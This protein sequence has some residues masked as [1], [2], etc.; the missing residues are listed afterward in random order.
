MKIFSTI[1][2]WKFEAVHWLRSLTTTGLTIDAKIASILFAPKR[3]DYY[4][5]LADTIQGTRGR[6]SLI[7]I[8]ASDVER[9]GTSARG[10][11]SRHWI[12][13][14]KSGGGSLQKT[15]AGTLP[16]A[17]V[18]VLDTLL[19]S[20]GEKALENALRDLSAN[21]EL[22]SKARFVVF[23]STIAGFISLAMTLVMFIGMP[24]YTVPKMVDAFSM[25]PLSDYPESARSLVELADFVKESSITIVMFTAAIIGLII[26]SLSN[27]TG[28]TRHYLD[29]YGLFWALHRDF[30]SIRFLSTL[31]A[32]VR[33]SD[34]TAVN[35]KD[36]LEMQLNGA[37]RWKK[38][39]LNS[40]LSYV[41]RGKVGPEIFTTGIMDK[42]MQ[43][44][45]SDL[46]ESRGF[47]DALQFVKERLKERVIKRITVQSVTV[48]WLL[49]FAS[50]A[51]S[52][53]LLKWHMDALDD[54]K[55]ALQLYMG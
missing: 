44:Y 8:F 2:K 21:S 46:I 9:Y 33:Q 11:L 28:R 14:F 45:I 40:I 17:D 32:L 25:L 52:A 16:A 55:S 47:S 50:L 20:G 48:A 38:Y 1:E 49:M 5:F 31:A 3:A 34:N 18:V 35:L 54:M 12:K 37:S 42:T 10:K 6:K 26:L 7:D 41:R 27:V 23:I 53:Y 13:Q 29:K 22:L 39:H 43:W 19:R 4:L 30:Q 36:A 15:F 24:A 51:V